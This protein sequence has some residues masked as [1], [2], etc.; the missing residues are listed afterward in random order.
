LQK[1]SQLHV[2]TDAASRGNPGPAAIGYSIYDEH[3]NVVESDAKRIDN[4]TN[5]S[6]E[7][8]ALIWAM[9][10]ASTHTDN[11]AAFYSDS[12][13]VINQIRGDYR[14]RNQNLA[15]LFDRIVRLRGL[16]KSTKFVHR[17]REDPRI[18]MEDDKVNAVLDGKM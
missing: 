10:R 8:Q 3:G 6:A 15:A 4:T 12:E 18:S 2:Y 14:V 1:I 11:D 5:N 9:E 17:P 16:F 7:Y 13:L